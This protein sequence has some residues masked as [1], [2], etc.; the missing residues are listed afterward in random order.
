MTGS[1][2]K[3]IADSKGAPLLFTTNSIVGIGN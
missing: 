1:D 2:G 3:E